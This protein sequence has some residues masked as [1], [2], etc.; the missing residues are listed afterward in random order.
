MIQQ[1]HLAQHQEAFQEIVSSGAFVLLESYFEQL[2]LNGNPAGA[3]IEHL[4]EAYIRESGIRSVFRAFREFALNDE[5]SLE[6]DPLEDE[7][8]ED[9]TATLLG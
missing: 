9:D 7:N 8:L 1:Q 4:G 3:S 2:S 6:V 5:H